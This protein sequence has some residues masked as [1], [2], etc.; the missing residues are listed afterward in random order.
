MAE[1]SVR[2]ELYKPAR[3]HERLAAFYNEITQL[4]S[5]NERLEKL[6]K[7]IAEEGRTPKREAGAGEASSLP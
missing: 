2:A 5:V 3:D 7:A 6:A 4:R 1:K